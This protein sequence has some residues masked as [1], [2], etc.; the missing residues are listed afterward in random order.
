[1][2]GH[3]LRGAA[4]YLGVLGAILVLASIVAAC[5]ASGSDADAS[6]GA[7]SGKRE[8]I[9]V[10]TRGDDNASGKTVADAVATITT[11]MKRALGCEGA[12]C[13][14]RIAVGEYAEQVELKGGVDLIGG[15]DANFDQQDA[16][17]HPVVITSS[18]PRT[19]IADAL[20]AP[21]RIEAITI[22]GA[23][24]TQGED[25]ASSTALWVNGS[26]DMLRLVR[27]TVQG[28]RGARGADGDDGDALSCATDGGDGGEA[29]DCGGSKGGDGDAGGDPIDGGE[30][31]EPGS[32]NCPSAC[33]LV[34]SDGISR[35][36]PGQ[37]GGDGA[38]SEPGAASEDPYG[39]FVGTQWV[40][41][42]G[43]AGARGKNGTS[44][45]RRLGR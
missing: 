14:L 15:F 16:A 44:G 27:T 12:P 13:A 41:T 1:M 38:D 20:E 4:P 22:T 8:V 37:P 3:A 19:M 2:S 11:G 45:G 18:E 33:P 24:L 21:V 36:T 43:Q 40:G 25:G 7:A 31:G 32:S 30:G 23:D 9:Y 35:G 39:R 26:K 34:G 6:S 5:A 42:T 28:G 29:F 10:A 17:A